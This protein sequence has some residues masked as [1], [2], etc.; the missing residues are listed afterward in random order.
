MRWTIYLVV[1]ANIVWFAWHYRQPPAAPV[2]AESTEG[3]AKLVLLSERQDGAAARP[4]AAEAAPRV[5]PSNARSAAACYTVGPF[6]AR[7]VALGA[8]ERLSSGGLETSL[9]VDDSAQRDGYWVLLP[10][11]PTRAEAMRAIEGLKQ[12]SV[13]DYFLVAAGESKN[14]VSLGVFSERA[15]AERRRREMRQLGFAPALEKVQLPDRKIWLDGTAPEGRSMQDVLMPL[16]TD[17]PGLRH[18]SV[19]CPPAG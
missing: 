14:G 6:E 18:E 5:T 7:R 15:R 17:Y 13:S 12:K 1:L 19:P 11:F 10:P 2:S 9:R 8:Q 3:V 16:R 4:P